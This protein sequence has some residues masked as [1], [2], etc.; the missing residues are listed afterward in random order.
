MPPIE[1]AVVRWFVVGHIRSV[2]KL[3]SSRVRI[4][5]GSLLIISSYHEVLSFT[6]SMKSVMMTASKIWPSCF[7]ENI[8]VG[9][10]GNDSIVQASIMFFV[11][12]YVLSMRFK[13]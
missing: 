1:L 11:D 12:G 10:A 9:M 3:V 2:T 8:T 13:V 5:S 6:I 4:L 7:H